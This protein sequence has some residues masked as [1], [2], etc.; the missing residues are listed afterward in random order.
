[1]QG[2]LEREASGLQQL[3][4]QKQ[5]AQERL[6]EMDQQRAKLDSMLA[7]VRL[8]CREESHTVRPCHA[9]LPPWAPPRTAGSP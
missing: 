7:D 9:R 8:K 4:A 2:D 1:M 6:Q 3:E 5:D